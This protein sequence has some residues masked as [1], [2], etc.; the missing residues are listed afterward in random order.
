MMS[1]LSDEVRRVSARPVGPSWS[2]IAPRKLVAIRSV[3]AKRSDEVRTI[4]TAP[5]VPLARARAVG[6][7]GAP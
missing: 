4:P 7:G 5:V 2:A 3:K 1:P 6:S